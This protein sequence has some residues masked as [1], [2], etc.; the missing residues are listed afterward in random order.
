[1]N[2]N[3]K[4]YN[5]NHNKDKLLLFRHSNKKMKKYHK[6]HL[7]NLFNNNKSKNHKNKVIFKQK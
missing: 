2:Y 7:S 1:M 5:N 3:R 6:N 4:D